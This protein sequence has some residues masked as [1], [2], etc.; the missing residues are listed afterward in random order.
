M[1]YDFELSLDEHTSLGKIVKQIKPN[2]HVLE[3]GPGNGRMTRYLIDSLG[4]QVSIVEFDKE[5][6]DFV[7]QFAKD[8]VY[9][10][11]EDYHWVEKFKNQKYDAIVFADVLEHLT[12][13][14]EV[15]RQ[16]IP[17]LSE[18]GQ[19]L[20]TFPNIAHNSVLID[21]FNN[22]LNWNQYGLLDATHHSF[23]THS[24]FIELFKRVGLNVAIED[25]T[26]SQVGQNEIQSRYEDLPLT[27]QYDFKNRLFGEVYQYFFALTLNPEVESVIHTPENSN[28]VKHVNIF[29]ETSEGINTI[30]YPLN[31]F[32]GENRVFEF[33]VDQ[34]AESLHIEP[35]TGEG[36]ISFKLFIDDIQSHKF[37]H[38]SIWNKN[39]IYVFN[40][41]ANANQ[42]I[43]NGT[44][45]AGKTVKIELEYLFDGEFSALERD[46]LNDFKRHRLEKMRIE[47]GRIEYEKQVYARYE[48]MSSRYNQVIQSKTWQRHRKFKQWYN[49]LFTSRAHQKLRE[50]LIQLNIESVEVDKEL[51]STIIKGWGFSKVDK[52]P[53]NYALQY[54]EGSYYKVTP[55]YRKDVND[56]LGLPEKEKY[57]FIIEVAQFENFGL[58]NLLVQT[59]NHETIPVVVNRYNLSN[60]SLYR[61]LR[62]L[63][64]MVRHLG[65]KGTV[66]HLKQRKN[67]QNQYERW[68]QENES[69]HLDDITKEIDQFPYKPKISI[70]VP[71][72]NVDE[73][74]LRV[75]V[76]SL[77]KQFY[78]N[79]ELCIADDASTQTHIRPLLEKMMAE[80]DRIKVVF[81][82]ENGHISEATNSALGICTG[83]YIGFMDNDD[84][85]APNALYEVVKALNADSQIDFIYTDEDKITTRGKRFDPFFKPNWNE[86]LLLGHNYITHF[87]VVKKDL[88]LREVGGLRKEYNGSQDYDFVLR[89]TQKARKVHHIPKIL[90]HWRTVETSTALDPQTKEY[91]YIAGR[92]ALE[93]H[94]EQLG[95]RG[96]VAMTKNYGAYKTDFDYGDKVK[97]S[98]IPQHLEF[99]NSNWVKQILDRTNYSNCEFLIPNSVDNIKNPRIKYIVANTTEELVSAASSDYLVFIDT[100]LLPSD[101]RWIEEMMNFM[102][103]RQT[104][105]VVGKI[106]NK[107]DFIT[108]IGVVFDEQSKSFQY[109]QFG[110]SNKTIGYYFRPVL[111]RELYIA[112]EDCFMISKSDFNRIQGFNVSDSDQLKGIGLSLKIQQLGK[113][114]IFTP[115][116]SMVEEVTINRSFDKNQEGR[117]VQQHL[118]EL[119]ADNYQNPNKIS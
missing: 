3:F 90:Y 34:K 42:F 31:N 92:K 97:V 29:V 24:G 106:L 20:V 108:N 44:Y 116:A 105:M 4:C 63:L 45:V 74:W 118:N 81:R 64:G 25:F 80:D 36:V 53:L 50:E 18:N 16:V 79:W 69:F 101:Y 61:R 12:N 2:S 21:L 7:M 114:I 91:A 23:F 40:G 83:D 46:I 26:Y 55:L 99:L 87:V 107:D 13:P 17:F 100:R 43:I 89:A 51:H 77:K 28:F 88:V 75:C 30:S 6:F 11:I 56:A 59:A 10:N 47:Q 103:Y 98:I 102:K 65:I 94:I 49:H 86:V 48:L 39:G 60:S 78:S 66:N 73:K 85:L 67:T 54:D 68:I 41:T 37:V 71:V 117:F 5:L 15:L 93:S 35:L 110:V 112:T 109:E 14:E 19:I 119:L 104:G 58:I 113:K 70:A 76:D 95:L 62:Y 38:Q 32:T 9:G 115:Y 33:D 72:Y 52:E 82:T 22:H 57:G 27:V 96:K 84:E 1:K 8:G 111:P